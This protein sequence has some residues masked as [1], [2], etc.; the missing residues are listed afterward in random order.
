MK[1]LNC[2]ELMKCGREPGGANEEGLGACAAATAGE[3]DGVHGGRNGGRACWV[4]AG[5][6]CCG[7][8]Q[9]MYVRKQLYCSECEF[10]RRVKAEEKEKFVEPRELLRRVRKKNGSDEE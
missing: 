4:V 8:T 1:K 3:M 9:G 7:K 2:W 6:F 10:F 5:T